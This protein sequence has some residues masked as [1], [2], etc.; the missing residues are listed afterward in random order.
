MIF[1]VAGSGKTTRLIDELDLERRVLLIT[2]TEN[3]FVHLRLRVLQKFGYM[4]PNIVVCTYFRFL[5]NFCYRPL[6]QMRLDSRGMNFRLP[7][8]QTSRLALTHDARYLDAS[9]RLYHNR[10]A[11]LLEVKGCLPAILARIERY[12]DRVF[13]DEVQDFGGHDFNLLSRLWGAN[14]DMLL[15]GDF[16]QHTFDTSRD[17]SVNRALHDDFDAYERRFAAHG[18]TV[19]RQ[20]LRASRRC[21]KTVCDFIRER[22]CIDMHAHEERASDLSIVAEASVTKELYR[23]PAIVKLFYSGH[24]RYRCFSNNWGASKGMDHFRDVCVVLGNDAWARLSAGGLQDLPP[25]TRNKLYVACSR[26]R[27]NL[28]LVREQYLR[29]FRVLAS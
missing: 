17:G 8:A 9:R 20:S 23:N 25:Q 29:E 13:V 24:S 7:P 12:F 22:L 27:G 10:L 18:I 11:K 1:A 28:F 21:S 3:N 2:Y 16:F 15:V 19:D 5:H 26:A 6:L 14:T 4:P